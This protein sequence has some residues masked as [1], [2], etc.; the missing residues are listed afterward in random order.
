[1]KYT[2]IIDGERIEIELSRS[3]PTTIEAQVGGRQYRIEAKMVEPGVYWFNWN[4]RSV[5]IS[6]V[7]HGEGYVVSLEGRS[8]DIEIVNARSALRKATQH[9]HA[10]AIDLRAPMPGKIVKVLVSE[11]AVVQANQGIV[12]MEAM[13]MQNEIKA[14]KNGV[15]KKV[16]VK[17]GAPVNAGDLL[18]VVE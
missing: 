4:N 18:A 14:P 16:A 17:E 2:A 9:G 10:G 7:P 3:K 12:V 5:E 13:K 11:G 15:V 1:M 8:A 6:V